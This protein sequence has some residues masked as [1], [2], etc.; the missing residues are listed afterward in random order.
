MKLE[1][2]IIINCFTLILKKILEINVITIIS[3]N[4]VIFLR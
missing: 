3:I 4:T 1:I 2:R